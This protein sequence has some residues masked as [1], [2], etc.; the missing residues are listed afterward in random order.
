MTRVLSFLRHRSPS[1]LLLASLAALAAVPV[2]AAS[3]SPLPPHPVTEP[4]AVT[5]CAECVGGA[6]FIAG[7]PSGDLLAAWEA[8]SSFRVF[9]RLFDANGNADWQVEIT[10]GSGPGLG[11]ITDTEEGW[12]VAFQHPGKVYAQRVVGGSPTG[13][14]RQLNDRAEGDAHASTVASSDD[15]RVLTTFDVNA[16]D[17]ARLVAQ[18][19]SGQLTPIGSRTELGPAHYRAPSAACFRPDGSA[20]IAWSTSPDL[21]RFGVA[22]RLM[23]EDG[24]LSELVTLAP[25][26]QTQ[27]AFPSVVCGP[28]G[29]YA[30]AWPT[31]VRPFAKKAWDPVWQWFD[32]NGRRRGR[33]V[34]INVTRQGDQS[35]PQLTTLSDGGVLAVWES[36]EGDETT[37][38]GRKFSSLGKARGGELI[39]RRIP[40]AE[41]AAARIARIP[42]TGRFALA[43]REAG[44]GWLQVFAE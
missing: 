39:L 4:L 23:Y 11:A 20:L 24:T 5:T 14:P 30:V 21:Q 41:I 43:W 3:P 19:L 6:P 16:T 37:L 15:D 38:R 27:A 28:D 29:S 35:W 36:H 13:A 9:L 8:G 18:L 12:V 22:A 32:K 1:S 25:D 42:G 2:L 34:P 26:R 40:G 33:V 31:N 17:G 44:Q 10:P 7:A